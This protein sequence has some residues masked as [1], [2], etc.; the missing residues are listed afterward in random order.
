MT[1]RVAICDDV[2]S[3]RT[4]LKLVLETSDDIDVVG[5][6]ANGQEAVDVCTNLRPDVLLLDVAM[7]VMD[8]LE[9]LPLIG[10]AS[11]QTGVVIL[12]G[13]SN[14]DVHD[15][16]MQNGA[17]SFLEK[18]VSTDEIIAAVKLACSR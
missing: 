3:F 17:V 9:A 6:A 10:T 12:S 2:A 8:G 15:R 16:A 5:E 4:L 13:F 1:C 7:P 18:G 14:S 11:P